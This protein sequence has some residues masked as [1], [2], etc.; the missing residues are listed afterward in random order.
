VFSPRFLH[1][2]LPKAEVM[3]N[4]F[5]ALA[6][7]RRGGHL[8]FLTGMWPLGVSYSDLAV[9]DWMAAALGLAKESGGA[10]WE[11][12]AME[13]G[14]KPESA[15]RDVA[16]ALAHAR[17]DCLAKHMPEL[18]AAQGAAATAAATSGGAS[19]GSS[20]IQGTIAAGGAQR[21]HSVR[22]GSHQDRRWR[23]E[24]V[25]G[26][27]LGGRAGQRGNHDA[28]KGASGGKGA[29]DGSSKVGVPPMTLEVPSP[30]LDRRP[31]P[32]PA[33]VGSLLAPRS[34]M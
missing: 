10:S 20:G 30:T 8:G 27:Q 33:V 11:E 18:A 28:G 7:T 6:A 15:Q 16:A 14:W 26:R 32:L 2:Y 19:D 4:P 1:S 9:D 12:R 22:S 23:L 13:L 34:K 17:C 21:Q 24:E 3:A 5:V 31:A 29:Q 25:L